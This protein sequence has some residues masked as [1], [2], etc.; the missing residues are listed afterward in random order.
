MY[1]PSLISSYLLFLE[2]NILAEDARNK[3][4]LYGFPRQGLFLRLHSG[5]ALVHP[6]PVEGPAV[7]GRMQL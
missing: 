2:K 6:E 5:C 3:K 7:F 1:I 4:T